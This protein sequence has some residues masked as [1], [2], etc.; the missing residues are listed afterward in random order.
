[1]R[2]FVNTGS[3]FDAVAAAR[4]NHPY[5]GDAVISHSTGMMLLRQ[6]GS[7]GQLGFTTHL[8]ASTVTGDTRELVTTL[9]G[10]YCTLPG[11]KPGFSFDERFFVYHHYIENTAADA[12]E[13][14]FSGTSDPGFAAYRTRAGAN[15]YLVDI[16]TGDT[17]RIT[18]M[19]P[20]Q[21]AFS[22]HFRSDGWIYYMVRTEG[23]GEEYVV[24]N[25]AALRVAPL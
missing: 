17:Y 5:E 20:G 25:D 1:V 21:Y 12:M 10:R 22:P 15:I 19:A 11:G 18:N 3:G 2:F 16:A 23:E 14:G 9:G 7:A 24:A 6:A 8:V 13:L 4:V